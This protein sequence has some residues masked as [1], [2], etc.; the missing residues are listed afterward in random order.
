MLPITPFPNGVSEDSHSTTKHLVAVL[1]AEG[2]T[3]S[4]I[5]TELRLSKSTVCFHKRTLGMAADER[6]ARRFDWAAIRAHYD[7]GH[8]MRECKV[9]F[10]FSNSAWNDAVRRG[11]I[12]PRPHGRPIAEIFAAGV[13]R[14]RWHLK[15]RLLNAGLK[16]ASCE[17]CGISEWL[18]AALS[19]ELHHINGDGLDNRIE[20]LQLL[21]PNCHSQTDTWGGRGKRPSA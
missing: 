7:A 16:D 1:L 18:G 9:R 4:E 5:A 14:N 11:D 15:A 17:E 2:L 21:C 13:R 3:V 8:S 6:F 20:N 10:G 12:L 19:L